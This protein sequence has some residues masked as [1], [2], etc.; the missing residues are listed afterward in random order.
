[1]IYELRMAKWAEN[2]EIFGILYFVIA[3]QYLTY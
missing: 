3:T 2:F 1:M